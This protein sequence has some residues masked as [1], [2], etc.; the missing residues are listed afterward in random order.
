MPVAYL[1]NDRL[2]ENGHCVIFAR[3]ISP[4]ELL[5]RV[6]DF[7]VVPIPLSRIQAEAI[8]VMGEDVDEDL[9][10]NVSAEALR[11]SGMFAEDGALLRAGTYADW[12]FV[13]EV[14]GAF[15]GSQEILERVSVG[16][17]ALSVSLSINKAAWISYAELGV[18]LT[19]FDPLQ[20]EHVY[21][22]QPGK[23]EELT[24]YRH[25]IHTGA[26]ED[27]YDRALRVIQE[28]LGC[29]VPQE[30]DADLLPAIRIAGAY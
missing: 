6:A 25:A 30:M 20:P 13:T 10:G 22:T 2:Y 15:L 29:T 3:G 11:D 4:V 5:S 21:G 27:A 28:R 8:S 26:R 14:G 12:S 16:T 19:S 9:L 18:T 1:P 23:L 7:P 17:A 24:S